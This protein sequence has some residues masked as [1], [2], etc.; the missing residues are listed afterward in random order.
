MDQWSEDD[1]NNYIRARDAWQA[2]LYDD[3][4][5]SAAAGFEMPEYEPDPIYR[6]GA[7]LSGRPQRWDYEDENALQKGLAEGV[8]E[9]EFMT[10]WLKKKGRGIPKRAPRRR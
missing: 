5:S 10:E 8:G 3:D 7:W 1:R 9:Q 6:P 2:A 4:I